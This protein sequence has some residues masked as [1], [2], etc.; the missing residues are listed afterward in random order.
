KGYIQDDQVIE[1][2][3]ELNKI[4]NFAEPFSKIV[5]I[6]ELVNTFNEYLNELLHEKRAEAKEKIGL[7]H[8][9]VSLHAKQYGVS[10]ETKARVDQQYERLLSNVEEYTDIYRIDAAITHS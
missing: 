2:M 9:E 6:P 8:G 3:E 10:N 5:E 1:A 7:D 4:Q